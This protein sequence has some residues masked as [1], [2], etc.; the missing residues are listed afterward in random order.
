[1][2]ESVFE[3]I[4]GILEHTST[5]CHNLALKGIAEHRF[6]MLRLFGERREIRLE[7]KE[8]GVIEMHIDNMVADLEKHLVTAGETEFAKSMRMFPKAIKNLYLS[9]FNI[10]IFEK[11]QLLDMREFVEKSV[12]KLPAGQFKQDLVRTLNVL[13]ELWQKDLRILLN[14]IHGVIA[15]AKGRTSVALGMTKLLHKEGTGFM[16]RRMIQNLVKDA[17]KSGE[18]A[19]GLETEIAKMRFKNLAD[20]EKKLKRFEKEEE[21]S[22]SEYMKAVKLLYVDWETAIKALQRITSV[23]NKGVAE[24]EMPTLDAQQMAKINMMLNDKIITPFAHSIE[25]GINQL[26][27]I[28]HD[29]EA[30]TRQLEAR[31]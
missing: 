29:I 23:V 1:M 20:A 14:G 3:N 22:L 10:M 26:D 15:T 21:E 16:R 8:L 12:K 17:F 30:E 27:A 18:K 11:K 2:E 13:I 28:K 5:K 25:I 4:M 24:H 19:V 9:T 7:E 31:A 6:P